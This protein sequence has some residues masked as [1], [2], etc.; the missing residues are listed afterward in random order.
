MATTGKIILSTL[1]DSSPSDK[2]LSPSSISENKPEEVKSDLITVE[3]DGGTEQ[4]EQP[5]WELDPESGKYKEKGPNLSGFKLK[6]K[7][8]VKVRDDHLHQRHVSSGNA[9]IK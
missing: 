5:W 7:M 2:D 9:N 1:R 8:R 6:L 4:T 3:S